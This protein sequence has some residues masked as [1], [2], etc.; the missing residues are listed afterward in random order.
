VLVGLRDGSLLR[1]QRLGGEQDS[2]TLELAT[3]GKL[4]ASRAAF[5][6]ALTLIQPLA[7]VTYV[8]DLPPLGDTSIPFLQIAWPPTRDLNVH[9]G[10]LRSSGT[11]YAKGLGMRSSS[12]SAFRLDADYATFQSEVALDDQAGRGGSVIFKLFQYDAS[13]QW[14]SVWESPIVRGGDPPLPVSADIRDARA[15]ALIVEFA[16]RGDV[17]DDA[18]WLNPCLLR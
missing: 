5:A 9:G 10:R 3:G 2:V 13:D 11:I 6:N 16:D 4:S 12:R 1:A 15:L 17:Q 7:S 8:S 14:R 18:N